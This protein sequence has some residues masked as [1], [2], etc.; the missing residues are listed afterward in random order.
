MWTANDRP[1]GAARGCDGPK[2][3]S[4]QGGGWGCGTA[5]QTSL[6]G[7]HVR[8]RLQRRL[9]IGQI[10]KPMHVPPLVLLLLT[11][12]S[13]QVVSP[14]VTPVRVPPVKVAPERLASV[15]LADDRVLVD[16]IPRWV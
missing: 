10:P 13:G 6:P 15:R 8:R 7:G 4:T 12:P 2:A 3:R 1:A 16:P 14:Q 5:S 11:L 9:S